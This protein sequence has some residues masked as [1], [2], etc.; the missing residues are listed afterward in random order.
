MN[1]EQDQPYIERALKGDMNAFAKLV[2]RYKFMVFTLAMRMVKNREEAEEISQD[3]FLKVYNA[4]GTFKG[5]SKFSTWVYKIAYYRSLDYIKKIGRTP[6]LSPI[7]GFVENSVVDGRD[8]I[9]QLEQNEK[10]G[11]IKEALQLLPGD[12]G[13]LITLHYFEELSLNEISVIMGIKV[14]NVKVKL[15]RARKRLHHILLSKL[16]PE[17]I[18]SYARR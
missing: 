9:D 14:N 11:A 15:F 2:D 1:L 5:D 18:S 3:T 12:D 17:I 16:E 6:N 8:V 10:R 7:E 4:L 13:I